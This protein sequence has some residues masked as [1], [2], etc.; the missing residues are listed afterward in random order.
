MDAFGDHALVCCCKGDRTLRHNKIRDLMYTD[1]RDANLGAEKEKQGL[2]PG[3][4]LEDGLSIKTDVRGRRPA[5]V[6]LPQGSRYS[7]GKPEALDF[8]VTSGL[9]A[10]NFNKSP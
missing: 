4:P 9:R 8:A 10:D 5:D 7:R 1:A 2:L 6:F 3:R